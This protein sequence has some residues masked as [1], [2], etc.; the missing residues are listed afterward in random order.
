M[1]DPSPKSQK[2]LVIVP[3]EVSVKVTVSGAAPLVG[4]PLKLATAGIAPLPE[5]EFAES[6]PLLLT[7]TVALDEP[8]AI[9]VKLTTRFVEPNAATLNGLPATMANGPDSTLAEPVN[10]PQVRLVITKLA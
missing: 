10:R 2:R 1:V 9:G 3:A 4:V 5:T 7:S 6:P 8:S